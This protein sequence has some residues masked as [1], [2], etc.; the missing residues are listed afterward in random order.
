MNF[1]IK[2]LGFISFI[3]LTTPDESSLSYVHF[4][5]WSY[6]KD[7]GKAKFTP[8]EQSDRLNYTPIFTFED[9]E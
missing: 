2:A 3:R 6:A 5:Y 8:L 4:N 7:K 9:D 1:E